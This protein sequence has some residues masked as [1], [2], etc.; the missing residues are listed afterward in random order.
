[1]G[2]HGDEG[3]DRLYGDDIPEIPAAGDCELSELPAGNGDMLYGHGGNDFLTG[4][5]GDDE[6]RGGDGNDEVCGGLGADLLF[7]GADNDNIFADI[8]TPI[9]DLVIDDMFG[10][11]GDDF[12]NSVCT[13][14][15]SF[16]EFDGEGAD[17][18]VSVQF[19]FG[20]VEFTAPPC[21]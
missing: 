21:P 20:E 16:T 6:L 15:D 17:T 18:A 13:D 12:A 14:P 4:G 11:F 2:I 1:M 5:A 7:G 9:G 3:V 19:E 8:N 10:G